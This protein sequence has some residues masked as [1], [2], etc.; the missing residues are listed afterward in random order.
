MELGVGW[1]LKVIFA[2]HYERNDVWNSN[3]DVGTRKR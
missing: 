3:D 2:K 1:T